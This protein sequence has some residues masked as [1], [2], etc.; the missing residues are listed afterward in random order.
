MFI[1]TPIHHQAKMGALCLRL[2]LPLDDI[3]DLRVTPDKKK[4]SVMADETI[5]IFLAQL[6]VD[7]I[8][9]TVEGKL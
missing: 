9:A 7:R 6:H 2:M 5:T 1:N 4:K 3:R 8:Q